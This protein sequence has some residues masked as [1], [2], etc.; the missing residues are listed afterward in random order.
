M[1]SSHAL[2]P[3]RK[4]A[5]LA[6]HASL[7]H[8]GHY[9]FPGPCRQF[10]C[11]ICNDDVCSSAFESSHNFENSRAFLHNPF[12]DGRFDHRVLAAYVISRHWLS[13]TLMGAPQNVDVR[14]GRLHHDDVRSFI[15]IQ[16][17]LTQGFIRVGVIHLIRTTI[18]KLRHAF[19]GLAERTVKSRRKFG[20]VTHDPNLVEATGVECLADGADPAVHH[21]AW[22]DHVRTGC[23]AG[24]RGFN[25]EIDR[26][27]VQ[28]MEMVTIDPCDA[29][30][31]VTHVFA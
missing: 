21:I 9:S 6:A 23:G 19:R 5:V 14:Q 2:A 20:C 8:R 29:A 18:A 26:L 10:A 3:T 11:P 16:S 12:L 31:T 1:P 15:D 28:Y 27:V 17:N 13:K 30:M 4:R 24:K 25:Q 7:F 22:C